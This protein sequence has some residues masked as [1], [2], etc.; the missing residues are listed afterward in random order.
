MPSRPKKTRAP[1]EVHIGL[2]AAAELIAALSGKSNGP[3][4]DEESV[5]QLP[6]LP[7]FRL[8]EQIG[9]GG[10]GVV[11]RAVREGGSDRMLAV[12]LLARHVVNGPQVQR[13]WRELAILSQLRLPAV[14]RV[15]DYGTHEGRLYIATEYIDGLRLDDYC[16]RGAQ[17]PDA[18]G[19]PGPLCAG[20]SPPP[21]SVRARVELLVG[22]A[23][24]VHA[25]HE[26]GVVHRDLKPGNILIDSA[27]QPAIID[28]GIASLLADSPLE[29]L[30][31]D[32]QP[33]GTPAFMSPEQAR[34]DRAAISTRSDVYSL[35]ATAFLV[36]TGHT[37]H[38]MQATIHEAIRRVAQEP[39]RDA[40]TLAP[41]LPRPL[42]AVLGKALAREPGQRYAS[43]AEFGA[44][45][46]RWLE[47]RAVEAANASG[48][49][50]SLRWLAGRPV[51]ATTAA[52]VTIAVAVISASF[53][54]TWWLNSRPAQVTLSE[55]GL[56][57]TVMSASGRVIKA[58]HAAPGARI[59]CARIV[60]R[61]PELG[62]GPVLLTVVRNDPPDPATDDQLCVWDLRDLRSPLWTTPSS[63]PDIQRP[64]PDRWEQDSFEV[65][66]VTVADVFPDLPGPEIVTVHADTR[67]ARCLRVYSLQGGQPLFEAWHDGGI[68]SIYWMSGLGLIV[69]VGDSAE[70]SLAELGYVPHQNHNPK[71][72]F[73]V[74]PVRGRLDG[75]TTG[76]DVLQQGQATPGWYRW[77]AP[78]R[79]AD[80]FEFKLAAPHRRDL[81]SGHV[82]LT[83]TTVNGRA[84]VSFLID[85]AGRL[86]PG[87]ESPGDWY[88]EDP[89]RLGPGEFELR[90][91]PPLPA[92][93]DEHR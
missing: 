20:P 74:R 2:G 15:I 14:P 59:R 70:Y 42:S 10:G 40:R 3:N 22:V 35:G 9:A 76:K 86:E 90:E 77:I 48:W 58:W 71:V 56:T 67:S 36:L 79:A 65:S 41:T 7:Q 13:A 81:R 44:D 83:L 26:R 25:L 39:A 30:T 32:G 19:P 85:A 31:S 69:C 4:G 29:T 82:M 27:G 88:P 46:R 63:A 49:D 93:R 12:K 43:A 54:T 23:E 52:C 34:G 80:D 55:D 37:P 33:I 78:I 51:A 1:E 53:V 8:I 38:D 66:V 45:L 60:E 11:Y 21:L 24:A 87:S 17:A 62:G 72:L 6:S 16:K 73:A 5:S 92:I 75:W 57:A 84:E 91:A 89:R 61:P 18:G 68:E 64:L 47:G 28:L 50:R